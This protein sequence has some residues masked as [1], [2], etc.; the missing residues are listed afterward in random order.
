M[1]MCIIVWEICLNYYSMCDS[2]SHSLG[3]GIR[4]MELFSH[5]PHRDAHTQMRVWIWCTFA[6]G[7]D[8]RKYVGDIWQH[9]VCDC[10]TSVGLWCAAEG[11]RYV[12]N[13]RCLQHNCVKRDSQYYQLCGKSL[14]REHGIVG[15]ELNIISYNISVV[16]VP[17]TING[18]NLLMNLCTDNFWNRCIL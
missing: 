3:I 12:A 18:L 16:F 11:E 2:D 5:C 1:L 8:V 13:V 9:L 14:V 4:G 7:D 6:K 17:L 10:V 15:L